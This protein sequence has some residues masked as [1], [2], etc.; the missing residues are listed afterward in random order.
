MR[1]E[2]WIG[3]ISINLEGKPEEI[4]QVLKYLDDRDEGI[5]IKD[6]KGNI[7]LNGDEDGSFTLNGAEIKKTPAYEDNNLTIK[8]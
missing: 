8:K 6:N 3:D 1:Y 4:I 5:I 7:V 2:K